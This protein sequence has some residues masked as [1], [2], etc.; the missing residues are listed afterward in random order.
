MAESSTGVSGGGLLLVQR[1]PAGSRWAGR[2]AILQLERAFSGTSVLP[3][4]P[5]PDSTAFTWFSFLHLSPNK[6]KQLSILMDFSFSLLMSGL[7][8]I[9]YAAMVSEFVFWKILSCPE[10]HVNSY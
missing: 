6:L 9:R 7:T 8:G 4:S 1:L 10:I 5:A 2:A 3:H